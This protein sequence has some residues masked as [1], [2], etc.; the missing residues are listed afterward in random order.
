M[1]NVEKHS[2]LTINDEIIAKLC[3]IE[4]DPFYKVR[5]NSDSG[6]DTD[7]DDDK[8]F[9]FPF[10]LDEHSRT[11]LNVLSVVDA[12]EQR[13]SEHSTDYCE[14]RNETV[15]SEDEVFSSPAT[16]P[17]VSSEVDEIDQESTDTS[18]Q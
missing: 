8:H 14:L 4:R 12:L 13:H 10:Q 2:Q 3:D 9:I 7:I 6:C 16:T 5:M 15:E 11:I 18:S 17:F 1:E